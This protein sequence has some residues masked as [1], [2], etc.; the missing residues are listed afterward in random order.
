MVHQYVKI[1]GILYLLLLNC[2]IG[3]IVSLRD[4]KKYIE[5]FSE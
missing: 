4:K 5:L 1:K 2:L 3:F